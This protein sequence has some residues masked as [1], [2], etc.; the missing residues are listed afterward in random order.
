[1]DEEK[2]LAT[3]GAQNPLKVFALAE[4]EI[5]ASL[6]PSPKSP[7]SRVSCWIPASLPWHGKVSIWLGGARIN[8]LFVS[9]SRKIISL[10]AG[11][12]SLILFM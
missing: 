5:L 3:R 4:A 10:L 8:R 12:E 7:I 1:M 6:V 11:I 9:D 2:G